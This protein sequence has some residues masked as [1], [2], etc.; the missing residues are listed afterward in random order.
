METMGRVYCRGPHHHV[1]K[2]VV[3]TAMNPSEGEPMTSDTRPNPLK[4]LANVLGECVSQGDGSKSQQNQS[5]YHVTPV[6][7]FPFNSRMFARSPKP[8]W[9]C[10]AA[11]LYQWVWLERSAVFLQT[12]VCTTPGQIMKSWK[13]KAPNRRLPQPLVPKRVHIQALTRFA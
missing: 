13:C 4:C 3:F 1:C 9:E 6:M 5:K 11:G 2:S 10:P 7:K 12:T 8:F